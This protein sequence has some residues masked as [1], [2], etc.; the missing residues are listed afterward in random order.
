MRTTDE[1]PGSKI[2]ARHGA[3]AAHQ[4]SARGHKP[5]VDHRFRAFALALL[6][7][8]I[9]YKSGELFLHI[10]RT[11]PLGS[12]FSCFWA[13]ARVALTMPWRVY[14]FVYV[15]QIQNW[16]MGPELRPFI[17][18]PSAFLIFLPFALLPKTFAY[19]ATMALTSTLLFSASQRA[20]A[21]WWWILF[22]VAWL[23]LGC[24]QIT[25]A[26][27]GLTLLG[28]TQR[29]RPIWA[30]VLFG[31]AAALKPQIM[32]L[33]PL[34]LLADRNWRSLLAASATVAL[35]CVMSLLIWGPD[36][37]MNWIGAVPRF[38][39]EVVPSIPS[40]RGDE[41][42]PYS[43]LELLGVPGA[44]AFILAPVALWLVWLTFRTTEDPLLR[45]SASLGG[46]LLISPYA[47]NYDAGVLAP[48]VAAL[49]ARRGERAWLLYAAVAVLFVISTLRGPGSLLM[50]LIP[51]LLA[52]L[53]R[54][55]GLAPATAGVAI[56]AG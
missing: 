23:I 43:A 15:T 55:Y 51:P 7:A 52:Q 34:G 14:D 16:P 28:L 35:L 2:R 11:Q 26:I 38:Q 41:I 29:D 5:T 40:L 10:A 13:G 44:L 3:I 27:G 54:R 6:L 21:P 20:G 4:K 31:L 36:L 50:G 30:G 45:L 42:T 12:D 19:A 48:G 33:L 8:V 46:A 56:R 24:G 17:Y 18:P 9:A 39:R 47:M 53:P 32:L 1:R 25:F 22:P 49:L 37:W